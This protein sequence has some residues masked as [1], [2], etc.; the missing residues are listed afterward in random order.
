MDYK[1]QSE[2][3]IVLHSAWNENIYC[4]YK[5]KIVVYNNKKNEHII[6][7]LPTFNDK[8]ICFYDMYYMSDGLCV[9]V[10]TRD[11]Y[12]FSL[13]LNEETLELCQPKSHK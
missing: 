8:I 3:D 1:I 11:Y 2:A 5:T 13:T 4:L 7:K 6:I 12:D 9:I 10:A